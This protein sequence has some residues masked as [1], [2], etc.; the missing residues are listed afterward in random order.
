[1]TEPR[2]LVR[3]IVKENLHGKVKSQT[4]ISEGIEVRVNRDEGGTVR[5]DLPDFEKSFVLMSGRLYERP[6]TKPVEAE[7][8]GKGPKPLPPAMAEQL[9]YKGEVEKVDTRI[10]KNKLTCSCGNT[11]WVKTADMF[12]VK[13]CK[14]CT[15]R[16]RNRR[17]T[18]N[19]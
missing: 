19:K 13:K 1:M 5:F 4:I 10:F 8:V 3:K 7:P 12:Q 16:D 6:Y 17:R 18:K 2:E 11:R 15:Y 9:D 14:P